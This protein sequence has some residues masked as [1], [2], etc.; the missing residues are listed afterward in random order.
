MSAVAIPAELA[1]DVAA[2][3]EAYRSDVEPG[4]LV[5]ADVGQR[6]GRWVIGTASV[7]ACWGDLDVVVPLDEDPDAAVTHRATAWLPVGWID[8]VDGGAAIKVGDR[9]LALCHDGRCDVRN[10]CVVVDGPKPMLDQVLYPHDP[11]SPLVLDVNRCL[12][13]IDRW[14][15]LPDVPQD[16]PD[17]TLPAEQPEGLVLGPD[18]KSTGYVRPVPGG[19][20]HF[21]PGASPAEMDAAVAEYHRKYV[22]T[23]AD[24][25][26]LEKTA[27]SIDPTA[28]APSLE[29]L[30]AGTDFAAS[31][32]PADPDGWL[33]PR[34][35][36]TVH[37]AALVGAE[38]SPG[39]AS[40][41]DSPHGRDWGSTTG[42]EGKAAPVATRNGRPAVR[43]L[44]DYVCWDTGNCNCATGPNG[45]HEPHCGLEPIIHVE[46]LRALGFT[47]PV[48][49]PSGRWRVGSHA[50]RNLW[51]G[52]THPEG[53]DVGRMDTPELAAYVVDA[54]NGIRSAHARGQ[55][56]ADQRDGYA[57][58]VARL[59]RERN[60]AQAEVERLRAELE[61]CAL[62][63]GELIRKLDATVEERDRAR[64][65]LTRI[66]AQAPATR[67]GGGDVYAIAE[68]ALATPA[69]HWT[70]RTASTA[71][72][73][74][75]RAA[76]AVL[77]NG[78]SPDQLCAC[79]DCETERPAI[80]AAW[81]L[82]RDVLLNGRALDLAAEVG[83]LQAALR[84]VID[85]DD[86][87]APP[88]AAQMA[89]VAREALAGGS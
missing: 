61:R 76:L 44:G 34:Q 46:E 59:T 39:E 3:P 55:Q 42:Y 10:P 80:E 73:E 36:A 81:L 88:V 47:G 11:A 15:L 31:L 2:R 24:L 43:I 26:R 29:K 71:E 35:H 62:P 54:V 41:P 49:I 72:A 17:A 58:D 14:A 77:V 83:R 18:G 5:L 16:T 37:E 38:P 53:V 84:D 45:E 51:V 82:A 70:A 79:E 63:E 19:E 30:L 25:D 33:T 52:G 1:A 9:V 4:A 67:S 74:R 86:P 89:E 56:I 23:E 60:D 50:P 65:A 68:A 78:V 28:P 13:R 69:T 6:D 64:D 40:T 22:T 48:G 20:L 66:A 7:H 32:P 85:L 75:L 57:E 8:P 27:R 21:P 87:G 12:R